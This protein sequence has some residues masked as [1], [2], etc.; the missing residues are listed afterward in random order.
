MAK[1]PGK[2]K[3]ERDIESLLA[4]CFGFTEALQ[5]KAK[6]YA[7][8]MRDNAVDYMEAKG[9]KGQEAKAAAAEEAYRRWRTRESVTTD[10]REELVKILQGWGLRR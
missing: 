5:N 7:R 8:I 1:K 3:A 6:T 4:V 10:N 2:T 9:I